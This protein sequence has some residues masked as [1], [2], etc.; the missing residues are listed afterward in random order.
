MKKV[1]QVFVL[2]ATVAIIAIACEPVEIDEEDM[3]LDE[4]ATE[5]EL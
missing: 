1:I 3:E 2:I 4:P 5:Q